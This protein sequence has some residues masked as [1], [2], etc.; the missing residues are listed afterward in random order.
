MVTSS[1]VVGSSAISRAGSLA[2][3]VA[4]TTRCCIPPREAVRR[5]AVALARRPGIPTSR[6]SSIGPLPGL[7][8][9]LTG[10]C[11]RIVS[12][13]C[14][15][16]DERR[17]ERRARVLEDHRDPVAAQPPRTAS[18]CSVGRSSPAK[19]DRARGPGAAPGRRPITRQRQ[20]RLAAARLADEAE[21]LALGRRS[22]DDVGQRR[23][24][25][26]SAA[27][28]TRQVPVLEH[29]AVT[30]RPRAGR[31]RRRSPSPTKVKREHG[32]RDGEAREDVGPRRLLRAPGSRRPASAPATPSAAARRGRGTRAPPRSGARTRIS[33]LAC[34]TTGP[35]AFGRTW[36][37][38]TERCDDTAGPRAEHVRLASSPPAPSRASTRARIG[39]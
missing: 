11:A 22:S 27:E 26:A 31:S 16:T 35:M 14:S 36:R 18:P 21:D 37:N 24:Q 13:T 32:D 3:A 17:V 10:R 12:A 4:I 33:T 6:S 2:R 9:R 39:R 19:R 15:P 7:A 38:S 23:H 20:R 30:G 5:V 34:T 29:G 8:R 28:D 1:A 25:R